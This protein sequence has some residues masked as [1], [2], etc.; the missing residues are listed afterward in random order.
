MIDHFGFAVKDMG[1][2]RAFYEAALGPLG[3]KV[4][5]SGDSWAADEPYW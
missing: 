5:R 2:S 1:K 4:L 3:L